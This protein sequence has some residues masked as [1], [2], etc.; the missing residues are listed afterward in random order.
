M[1]E[2]S[3][4]IMSWTT[5]DSHF[6]LFLTDNK[7]CQIL[8]QLFNKYLGQNMFQIVSIGSNIRHGY[9]I[10]MRIVVGL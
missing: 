3:C 8:D 7:A 6:D 1:D 2:V 5:N 10:W 9:W 4:R